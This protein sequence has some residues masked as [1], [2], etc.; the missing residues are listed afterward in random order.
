MMTIFGPSVRI[1][2]YQFLII[3]VDEPMPPLNLS[4]LE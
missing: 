1:P 4:R 2:E 3:G